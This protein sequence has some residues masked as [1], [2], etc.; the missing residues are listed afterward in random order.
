MIVGGALNP[1]NRANFK[2]CQ[3]LEHLA[4]ISNLD[5]SEWLEL[6]Q[7]TS[8]FITNYGNSFW[9]SIKSSALTFTIATEFDQ[10]EDSI[11]TRSLGISNDMGWY[12]ETPMMEYLAALQ[13]LNDPHL[14][15]L[16]LAQANKKQEFASNNKC[17]F[18][19]FV[20]FLLFTLNK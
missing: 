16:I 14:P 15:R 3:G 17:Q 8:I 10:I 1:N 4:Y 6:L 20:E 13:L 12:R 9:E 11:I 19:Q 18:E 2:L 7:N 5:H